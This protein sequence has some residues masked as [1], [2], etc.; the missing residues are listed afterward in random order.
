MDD[1]E[2]ILK[3]IGPEKGILI[4]TDGVFSMTGDICPLPEIVRLAKNM[5]LASWLMMRMV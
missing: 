4:V 2:K 5:A 3:S 1:L